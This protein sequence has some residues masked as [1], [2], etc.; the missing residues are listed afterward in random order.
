MTDEND[1]GPVDVV[2]EP[3]HDAIPDKVEEVTNHPDDEIPPW[4]KSLTDKV[5]SLIE[6]LAADVD[7]TDDKTVV[8]SIPTDGHIIPDES[9][10]KPPWTH[11]KL[12]G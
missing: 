10:A 5:D 3:V 2:T 6:R 1:D 11:R 9:P 12:F 8:D 7:P 4:G